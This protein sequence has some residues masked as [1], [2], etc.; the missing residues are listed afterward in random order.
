MASRS[1][2]GPVCLVDVD[3][4]GE[5]PRLPARA[6][7]GRPY[8]R[9]AVAV[10]VHH[11]IVGV[12]DLQIE[13]EPDGAELA[14]LATAA[15]QERINAHL[16]RDGLGPGVYSNCVEPRCQREHKAF[17]S[18]APFASVVIATR[19][20]EATLADTLD[21]L[22]ANEYPAFEIVVVDNASRGDGV[23]ALVETYAGAA[24]PVRYVREDRPGLAVAHNCGLEHAT[25]EI[26]AFV[27]DDVI[28]DP[29]WLAQTGKAFEA[30]PGVACVTG[31]IMAAELESPAQLWIEGYW[32]F[33][34]GFDRRIFDDRRPPGEPLYPFTAGVFGSGAN[35]AFR[36]H[37]LRGLGGFDPGLGTGSP[38]LGGDDLAIFFD[39][40]AAGH[41][42]V[43]EPTAVVRHRHRR[44]YASLK[45][46][47]Y[48]YGVGLTA[49]LAKTL[50][51]DPRRGLQL[52][53]RAPWA[54]A[55]ILLPSSAKNAGRPAGLPPEL[56][57][58]ER[59]GMLVGGFAYMRSRWRRRAMYA[60]AGA[61]A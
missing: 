57:R 19:D 26:V 22:L 52:S 2:Q 33:A 11:Q 41:K 32:G 37:A 45:R 4:G 25:G 29:R 15:L 59:R 3:A 28:A 6:S 8:V 35:M 43:Y 54:L 53:L 48:G 17:M 42:L 27:D 14:R 55:H 58:I 7:D 9:A 34:K 13:G 61:A 50:I 10:R 38:A 36:T 5:P 21:S 47:A 12:V 49:Y 23:R 60:R 18:C 31:L 46:Q 56:Q 16:V 44:D 30:A 20:G 40:I 39:V 51:D 24:H 1:T